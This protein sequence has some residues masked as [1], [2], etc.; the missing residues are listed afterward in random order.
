MQSKKALL[1]FY[2]T[3]VLML[4]QEGGE[5]SIYGKGCIYLGLLGVLGEK[6]DK[7]VKVLNCSQQFNYLSTR[8]GL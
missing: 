7:S 8:K 2:R 3:P 6:A 4:R 5:N 1:E